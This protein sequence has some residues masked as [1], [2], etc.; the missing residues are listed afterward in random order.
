MELVNI[1]YQTKSLT[2]INI[3]KSNNLREILKSIYEEKSIDKICKTI[4]NANKILSNKSLNIEELYISSQNVID[5]LYLLKNTN[6]L[7][8]IDLYESIDSFNGAL[9]EFQFIYTKLMDPMYNVLLSKAKN[10]SKLLHMVIYCNMNSSNEINN[11]TKQEILE[12]NN[13]NPDATTHFIV[14]KAEYL[15]KCNQDLYKFC[16]NI[17]KINNTKNSTE[18]IYILILELR[19][20]FI[21]KSNDIETKRYIYFNID[22]DD[23]RLALQDGN[24]EADPIKNSIDYF[25]CLINQ[26]YTADIQL[27]DKLN[28]I[29]NKILKI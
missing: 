23:I 29:Y 21:E 15:S 2:N 9:N 22:I 7:S 5:K 14:N 12:M 19:K 25:S 3:N 8:K 11:L 17:I 20:Y 13:I 6:Y 28:M 1:I 27:I 24:F 18:T 4:E 26:K 10:V 16:W